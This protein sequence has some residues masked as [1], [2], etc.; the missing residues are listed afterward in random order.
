MMDGAGTESLSKILNHMGNTA[1]YVIRR[2][3]H[4]LLFFNDK[5][6][7]ITPDISLGKI[8]HEVWKGSC[9]NCPLLTMGDQ[10]TNTRVSYGD[11]FGKV[12]DISATKFTWGDENIP[13]YLISVT[14]HVSSLEE[15]KLEREREKLVIVAGKEYPVIYSVNLTKNT[16]VKLSQ[17]SS[18]AVLPRP[19]GIF[20]DLPLTASETV[21]PDYR[22]RYLKMFNRQNLLAC[23]AAGQEEVEL[24]FPQLYQDGNYKWV[25]VRVVF[26][27]RMTE[28]GDVMEITLCKNIDVHKKMKD[29]LELERQTAFDSIPGGVIKCLADE[30]FT[31]MEISRNC[32]E[33]LNI[34]GTDPGGGLRFFQSKKNIEYCRTSSARGLPVNFDGRVRGEQG[35]I[36]WF[37]IEGK[38]TGEQNGIAE[39]TLVMLDIT[40]RKEAE[41]ELEQEK[42]KYRIAVENSADV[43]FEYYPE[44]D[45]F[46]S[47]ENA[48]MGGKAVRME[49]YHEKVAEVIYPPDQ[50]LIE[51]LIMGESHQ[52]EVRIIPYQGQDY[53][54]YLIQADYM[55]GKNGVMRLIGTMR[56]INRLK[57]TEAE[58]RS[59]EKLL[60]DSVMTL[61]GEFIVLNLDTGKFISYKS[62]ELMSAIKE[63][64]NFQAFNK[65]YGETIVHPED[66]ERFFEFYKLDH[67]RQRIGNKDR[68]I[69]L[70]VRRLNAA[71]EYRWCEMIGTLLE[72]REDNLILLT[73]RDIH[74]LHL[75]LQDALKMAEQANTAKSDFL[76]RMSHD[77]RTPM[78]AIMGMTSIAAANLDNRTKIEDCLAKIGLSAKFLLSLLN[79]VLDMSRIESGKINIVNEPFQIQ[80]VIE[81]VIL[82]IEGQTKVK[83]QEL[84]IQIDDR[85]KGTYIGDSLRVHQ[86]LMNLL[87]NAVKYTDEAGQVSLCI[88]P[89][90]QV[91]DVMWTRIV[92]KDNGIGMSKEFQQKIF[93]P[94]EQERQNGGRVFEG[95]GLGLAIVQ[96]LIH[97]MGGSISVESS[98]GEGSCFTVILP[99]QKA[100]YPQETEILY[101]EDSL[102]DT[103]DYDYQG[104]QVLLVEDSELNREIAQTIL[105]MRGLKVDTAENG[106]KAVDQFNRSAPGTYRAILMDIRMPVMDGLKA[107]KMIRE[108]M[109]PEAESIPI[110]AMTANAFENERQE[111]EQMGVDEYLT[112]PIDQDQLF[113]TL[114][115][116][117][118]GRNGKY[119][120][121]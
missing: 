55:R 31:I 56:D 66:R 102:P 104:E 44:E 81:S 65:E 63:Q 47:Q 25:L 73:F 2:D 114:N 106:K 110:I 62:D 50:P 92:V 14:P 7:E 15:Q 24:E 85:V 72:G 35:L 116:V 83:D 8:C 118:R 30:Q 60:I 4:E 98:Q 48:Q 37:H 17:E 43:I 1:V 27:E 36:Q 95:S 21:H 22:E 51:Q 88:T 113:F 91:Q 103:G 23:Y 97:M 3:T 42:L 70:E 61:F 108:G 76:S 16:Y 75:V 93:E 74:E 109:H 64:E 79:D 38:K 78:N 115:K 5:V 53:H 69:I 100:E 10:E 41:A 57:M 12:V 54:W 111:A 11:P 82:L 112:K 89:I 121:L 101:E 6:N 13:A 39:Y 107:T 20:D 59:K 40:K 26:L 33:M 9:S 120:E 49:K 71:G 84:Q 90:R 86:I 99:M 28:Q 94:F 87:T 29:Q 80:E 68:R 105:E 117:L 34:S 19:S 67:I 58:Y 119:T 96:N 45:L 77:I 18:Q 52:A 46:L 32:R